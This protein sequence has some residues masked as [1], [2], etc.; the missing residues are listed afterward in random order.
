MIDVADLA[1]RREAVL[2]NPTNFARRQFHQ[3]ITGFE[4]S[5]RSLLPRAAR[6][7]AAASRSQFNVVNIRAQRNCAERQRIPQISR[8]IISGI[9]SRSDLKSTWRENVT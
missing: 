3:R 2:V 6:D 8:D 9:N 1:N 7:L 5:K 4:S